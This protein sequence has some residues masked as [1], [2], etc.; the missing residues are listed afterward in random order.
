[1]R[2]WTTSVA[3]IGGIALL[4]SLSL[5]AAA[6][7]Q[8]KDWEEHPY[9][10]KDGKVDYGT[11]DGYRRYAGICHVCHGPDGMGSSFAPSLVDSLKTMS[12]SEFLD[13]V[14]NGKKDVSNTQNLVMPSFAENANVMLNIDHIY[15]YLKARADGAVGRGRPERLPPEEDP[16]W[17][18]WKASQ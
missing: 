9:I 14:T 10:V 8:D 11:Y 12:Y 6:Y 1:M 7:A 17:K 4:F 18:E 13:I 3:R 15:A 2:S 5:S 16:V